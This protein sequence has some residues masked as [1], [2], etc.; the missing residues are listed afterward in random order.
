MTGV[1]TCA[2]PIC[3][4][5]TIRDF[6]MYNPL[7]D[8]WTE[9]DSVPFT[10]RVKAISEV[11][12][13][14]AYV[15]LGYNGHVYVDSAYRR[16][17]WR[18]DLQTTTWTRCAD[19]PSHNADVAASFVFGKRIFVAFGFF[20]GF[21][22][23]VYVYDTQTDKWTRCDDSSAYGRAGAVAVGEWER[24]ERKSPHAKSMHGG[25][26]VFILSNASLL[27]RSR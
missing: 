20:D 6:W 9:L 3:F 8:K 5:V 10:G 18:Y 17:F 16:D 19:F 13:G 7:T 4:P 14:S 22:H 1:Q 15:G 2:L 25:F 26:C 11:V 21:T 23:D 27:W 12:D 24:V